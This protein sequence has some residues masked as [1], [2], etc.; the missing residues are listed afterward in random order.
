M[1][2]K[3]K[4][5][6]KKSSFV[7]LEDSGNPYLDNQ[8]GY[9]DRLN[10]ERANTATWKHIAWLSNL[11]TIIAVCGSIYLGSLPDIKPFIFKEDGS[12]GLTA[13]GLADKPFKANNVM[14]AAEVRDFV[15]AME[16]VPSSKDLRAEN[17]KKV[18]N[19]TTDIAFT[20]KF[21]PMLKDKYKTVG[22]GEVIVRITNVLPIQKNS[23]S[24][25]W[26]ETQNGQKTA[27]FKGT[28]TLDTLKPDYKQTT[29][30]M[31]YNPLRLVV[32]DFTFNENVTVGDKQ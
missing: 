30:Q 9:L 12:G 29:E 26:V 28:L 24:I 11:I 32:T 1:K 5:N 16:Q 23:W 31:F 22:T 4:T 21:A 20:N 8:R 25:D 3:H 10:E 2:F 13:L 18:L 15:I 27:T 7:P 14:V 6:E 19:M 17:V